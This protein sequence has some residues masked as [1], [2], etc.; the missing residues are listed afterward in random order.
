MAALIIQMVSW[1]GIHKACVAVTPE[2]G[3]SDPIKDLMANCGKEVDSIPMLLE[4]FS[5]LADECESRNLHVH[6]DRIR[7][8]YIQLEDN[9]S[10]VMQYLVAALQS[11]CAGSDVRLQKKTL[12]CLNSIIII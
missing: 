11:A 4:I 10:D 7:S 5:A 3:V 8:M 6:P 9:S 1:T 12:G 2:R